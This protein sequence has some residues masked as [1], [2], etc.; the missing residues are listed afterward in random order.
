MLFPSCWC[1]NKI[2]K[3]IVDEIESSY[4]LEIVKGFRELAD[5]AQFETGL[6]SACAFWAL[7]SL[8]RHLDNAL[9]Q[10][11]DYGPLGVATV[12]QHVI[13]RLE[14]FVDIALMDHPLPAMRGTLSRLQDVLI[15]RWSDTP[16][17]PV[18]PAFR[19]L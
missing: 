9:N 7:S 13:S 12:R 14:A 19:K 3:F 2:P 18:Y 15:D 8:F 17:M 10:E 16:M 4:R 11:K 1:A 5:D 6:V